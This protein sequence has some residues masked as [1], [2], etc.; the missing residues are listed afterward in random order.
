MWGGGGG[1]S[2]QTPRGPKTPTHRAKT[3]T[4]R[5]PR[6]RGNTPQACRFIPNRT[7]MDMDACHFHLKANENAACSSPSKQE[8]QRSIKSSLLGD[9]TNCKVLAFG[10]RPPAPKEGFQSEAKVLFTQNRTQK[11]AKSAR[12]IPQAA[13]RI[14]DAP[15]YKVNKNNNKT[16]KKRKENERR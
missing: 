16:K 6:S 14:L 4:H 8:Y 2:V 15:G 5:T 1:G 13:E 3:P 7:L 12:H 10:E 9:A 11:A